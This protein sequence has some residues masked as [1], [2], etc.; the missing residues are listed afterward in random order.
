MLINKAE[1]TGRGPPFR[2]GPDSLS[3]EVS[4]IITLYKGPDSWSWEVSRLS[5]YGSWQFSPCTS[6][7]KRGSIFFL[8]PPN[9]P[10]FLAR[11]PPFIFANIYN[12]EYFWTGLFHHWM[13]LTIER[14]CLQCRRHYKNQLQKFL[15][16]FFPNFWNHFWF[17]GRR[18]KLIDQNRPN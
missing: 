12:S 10:D 17:I 16:F 4:Q 3:W 9:L 6:C 5:P 15:I 11:F 14:S 18:R 2:K 7:T 13:G 8:K 1:D